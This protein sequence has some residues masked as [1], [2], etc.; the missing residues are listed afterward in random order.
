MPLYLRV[1]T[2]DASLEKGVS[3]DGSAS[4]RIGVT[5]FHGCVVVV[6]G[7]VD[8]SHHS[9]IITEEED[10]ETGHAI[11]GDQQ[12]SLLEPV[13]D[14]GFWNDVHSDGGGDSVTKARCGV[15]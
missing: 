5:K 8:T 4:N 13:D 15:R 2:H 1:I 3:D 11:D 7:V 14:I 10:T 6:G 9:L 12:T